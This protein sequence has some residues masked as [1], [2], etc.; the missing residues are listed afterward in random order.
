M[1]QILAVIGIILVL[2][3]GWCEEKRITDTF[4]GKEYT[5]GEV[6]DVNIPVNQQINI[7]I[8]DVARMSDREIDNL[9]KFV[10]LYREL[11]YSTDNQFFI[12]MA[13]RLLPGWL[14]EKNGIKETE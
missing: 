2:T 9:I 4:T 12:F 7:T 10:L 6:L 5:S 3:T 8:E 13:R 11:N 1:K 14:L